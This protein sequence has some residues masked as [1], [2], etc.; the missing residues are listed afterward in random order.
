LGLTHPTFKEGEQHSSQMGSDQILGKQA[1][2]NVLAT[3]HMIP[4]HWIAPA[5]RLTQSSNHIQLSFLKKGFLTSTHP[6]DANCT[7]SQN[8]GRPL[9]TVMSYSKTKVI[10]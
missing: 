8:T 2:K 5:P 6:E 10:H 9:T 1:M 4:F 3:P 7:I